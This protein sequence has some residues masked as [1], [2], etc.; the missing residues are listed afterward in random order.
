[1]MK[2]Y[3][4]NSRTYNNNI[5]VGSRSSSYFLCEEIEKPEDGEISLTW[6]NIAEFY[7]FHGLKCDFNVWET[8]K[9]KQISFFNFNIF[10]KETWDIKEWKNK[11]NLLVSWQYK[12]CNPSIDA[13][14][15]YY[16]SAKAIKYLKERSMI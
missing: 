10:K 2:C 14:L 15:K 9:G 13:I 12:E 4:C 5:L 7:R 8:K 16:D 3:R 6:E 11:L 1:M